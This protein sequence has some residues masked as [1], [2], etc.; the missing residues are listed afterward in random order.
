MMSPIELNYLV[1]MT[2]PYI[3]GGEHYHFKFVHA[4]VGDD[5][6]IMVAK[7]AEDLQMED[8]PGTYKVRIRGGRFSL[9]SI[10]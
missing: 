3:R 9:T 5:F 4:N 2:K 6:H 10:F 1:L 7:I 8:F